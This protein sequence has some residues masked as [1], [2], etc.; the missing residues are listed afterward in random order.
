MKTLTLSLLAASGMAFTTLAIAQPEFDRVEKG[1]YLAIVGDCA[2]CHTASADKPF[3]GGVPINTP[4]GTLVGANITP[5]IATGIGAWSYDDFKRAMSEGI[6][7][8]DKRLYG[9]MP[10]TAYTKV[11]DADN[12]AIWSYLQT[13]TPI[14]QQIDSNQLP[15]PFRIRTSLMVWNWMNFEKGEYRQDPGK[16][17]E[18]NRGAYLVQGLGHCGTCHT[19]KNILGGDKNTHFL[20][21][22]KVENWWAP[23]ITA[24][25][26][27]G[28][29]RWSIGEIK[30]YLRTGVNR[31]D[32]ASGPMAEEVINSSRHWKESDLQA[33]AVYLKSLKPG[34]SSQQKTPQA[35]QTNNAQMQTGKAIYF[36]RCSACHT[37]AGK[38]APG[39]FP[40]LAD[41]PLIN[42]AQPTSLMLVVLA[43]SRAVG[44]PARPTAP[45]MPAFA[46]TMTDEQVADVLTYIR[47]SWGNAAPAVSASEVSRMR[48]SL[49]E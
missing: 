7:H 8:G 34:D 16:S 10:F 45:A 28:I 3:A 13:L 11:T 4:F 21:G 26:H 30:D 12:R 23:N 6:G 48:N 9:A 20:A 40:Q 38:G 31:Y 14:S 42:A 32:A 46:D 27:E 49:K 1:R 2:A 47:N 43:G 39:I 17:E 29:G 25:N 5:D 36:D 41:N 24:E 35:L 33:V 44:T 15:F 19:P 37:S 18:W 22:A